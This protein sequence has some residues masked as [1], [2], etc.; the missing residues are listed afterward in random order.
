LA[1]RRPS[2][3]DGRSSVIEVFQSGPELCGVLIAGQRL[4]HRSLEIIKSRGQN[5][6]AGRHTLQ[7]KGGKGLEVFRRVQAPILHTS[8]QPTSSA[9]R[10]VVGVPALDA[11]IGGG[12]FDGSTT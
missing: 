3:T 11:L 10:S 5:Y 12:L 7:I 4:G 1:Q 6:V 8:E 2:A 9:K